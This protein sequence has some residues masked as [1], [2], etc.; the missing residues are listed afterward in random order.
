[1]KK[2]LFLLTIVTLISSCKKEDMSKYATK[3]ELANYGAKTFNFDLTFN[4]GD[5]YQSFSGITGY[6]PGDVVITFALYEQLGGSNFWVQMPV[7]FNNYVSL[8]PEFS[9]NTGNLF[10]NT[11]FADGSAGSP[12][13]T[14]STFSF[15]AVLI[16]SSGLIQHPDVDLTSY[17][18]VKKAFNLID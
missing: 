16:K 5:T 2:L 8:I 1:M 14:T 11:L 3:D 10:I 18:A 6:E 4:A 12:W 17:S 15:K 13:T 7:I 9:D